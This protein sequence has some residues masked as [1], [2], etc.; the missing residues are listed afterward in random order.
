MCGFEQMIY[1]GFTMSIES[2]GGMLLNDFFAEAVQNHPSDP[3]RMI[4][5]I[6]AKIGSVDS[7]RREE[8]NNLMVLM[9]CDN[10]EPEQ[11]MKKN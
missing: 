6:N 1:G 5:Y 9:L 3:K 8:I 2:V 7:S 10:I 4:E 11:L